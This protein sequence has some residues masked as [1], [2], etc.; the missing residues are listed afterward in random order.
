MW[1]QSW[2]KHRRGIEFGRQW[3]LQKAVRDRLDAGK[4]QQ[5]CRMLLIAKLAALQRQ[6]S[7]HGT[8]RHDFSDPGRALRQQQAVTSAN[9]EPL[10]NGLSSYQGNGDEIG[11]LAC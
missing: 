7:A 10:L 6:R 8:I 5:H 9:D 2:P 11:K 3:Q 1:S 4:L